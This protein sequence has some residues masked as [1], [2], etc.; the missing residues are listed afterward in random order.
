MTSLDA[1]LRRC[2]LREGPHSVSVTRADVDDSGWNDL[3]VRELI[4]ES[5]KAQRAD[6]PTRAYWLARAAVQRYERLLR[7]GRRS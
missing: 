1:T 7:E 5:L 3:T 2:A 6:H 4:D